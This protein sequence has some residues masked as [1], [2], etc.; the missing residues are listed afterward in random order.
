LTVSSLP[1]YDRR[2]FIIVSALLVF[3]VILVPSFSPLGQVIFGSKGGSSS[4]GL[5]GNEPVFPIE[6][7]P[8]EESSF[9]QP[10]PLQNAQVD[11]SDFIGQGLYARVSSD[12]NT[13]L[14]LENKHGIIAFVVP[15]RY[16]HLRLSDLRHIIIGYDRG[17]LV[18]GI[19]T[20]YPRLRS[21]VD[22]IP[23]QITLYGVEYIPGLSRIMRYPDEGSPEVCTEC[24]VVTW[25][26]WG[27]TFFVDG[28][29][30]YGIINPTAPGQLGTNLTSSSDM[31]TTLDTLNCESVGAYDPDDNNITVEYSFLV[32]A[33]N[34][35]LS[36]WSFDVNTTSVAESALKD[37]SGNEHN[38][39][40]GG[41]ELTTAPTWQ[42]LN[43]SYIGGSFEFDGVDDFINGTGLL[44]GV[45]SVSVTAWVNVTDNSNYNV[46]FAEGDESQG[47]SLGTNDNSGN[48]YFSVR[49]GPLD[50]NI[51][52]AAVSASGLLQLD[53][54]HHLAGVYDGSAS[55]VSLYVDG[56]LQTTLSGPSDV[57]DPV[58]HME[59]GADKGMDVLVRGNPGY[60]EGVIDQVMVYDRVLSAEQIFEQAT[61]NYNI[62]KPDE[63]AKGQTWECV[64]VVTDGYFIS[65]SNISSPIT[66]LNSGPTHDSPIIA[67]SSGQS[68]SSED[69]YCTN[70]NTQ[71]VDNDPVTNLYSFVLDDLPVNVVYLPFENHSS[72]AT[73]AIGYGG[74]SNNGT[75]SG[76]FFNDSGLMI[77]GSYDFDGI[78]DSIIVDDDPSLDILGDVSIEVWVRFNS[79]ANHTPLV[80]RSA[81]VVGDTDENYGL[82]TGGNLTFT[83]ENELEFIYE[84]GGQLHT[85]TTSDTKLQPHQIYHIVATQTSG[86]LPSIFVDG[87]V[88]SGSCTSGTCIALLDDNNEALRIGAAMVEDSIHYFNGTLDEVRVYDV[89]LTQVQ[90]QD[91]FALLYNQIDDSM[92]LTGD[93]WSCIVTPHDAVV[94]GD[95]LSS[96]SIS[97]VEDSASSVAV[98]GGPS[99]HIFDWY[100]SQE[101]VVTYNL[102]SNWE[103]RVYGLDEERSE[104]TVVHIQHHYGK[105][106]LGIVPYVGAYIAYENKTNYINLTATE[107]Y[108][109]T[110]VVNSLGFNTASLTFTYLGNGTSSASVLPEPVPEPEPVVGGKPA[111]PPVLESPE[112]YD[113]PRYV[114]S[115]PRERAPHKYAEYR[116]WWVVGGLVILIIITLIMLMRRLSKD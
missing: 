22:R 95:T 8:Y 14:S 105:V 18:A 7:E 109:I 11:F 48:V 40:L 42:T 41:G 106:T 12:K 32:N 56:V 90:I 104:I 93:T 45:D 67:T 83:D 73:L 114:S 58:E 79:F 27:V 100:T 51:Y 21:M 47:Y 89:P 17:R 99:I 4:Y 110:A 65:H 75:V 87:V 37:F 2:T 91:N 36:Q 53:A 78:D 64:T 82:R 3:F 97:L 5:G 80:V 92:T 19:D 20:R 101:S 84:S 9:F 13:L 94:A 72:T 102:E 25:G 52:S 88:Q 66:I 50:T 6:P 115:T 85:F 116:T 16:K 34:Y 70:Q 96:S 62:I 68:L 33:V 43:N 31:N 81:S 49:D 61:G 98:T 15:V 39:T 74:Y 57:G 30:N 38:L 54:Y 107:G 10:P 77:G 23:A 44:N 35:S 29:S 69:I 63:T 26:Y 76:A 71:D 103:I 55:S 112:S 86:F 24:Y 59:I 60:F 113:P 111:Q 46:V 108:D 1:P 28:F